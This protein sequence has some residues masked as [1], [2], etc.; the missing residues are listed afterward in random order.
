MTISLISYAKY[1]GGVKIEAFWCNNGTILI[2][3]NFAERLDDYYSVTLK[4]SELKQII[5]LYR[6]GSTE[7]LSVEEDRPCMMPN[8]E[9]IKVTTEDGLI[10]FK[11]SSYNFFK[12]K[13]EGYG[14]DGIPIIRFDPDA[15]DWFDRKTLTLMIEEVENIFSKC[16]EKRDD[17]EKNI[18]IA[19]VL[20]T[21]CREEQKNVQPDSD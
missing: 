18:K 7:L 13:S 21:N 5:N 15:K 17:Y 11:V 1:E 20:G 10:V 6:Q 12:C 3:K 8:R 19:P 9:R 16:L 4:P 14:E 2:C